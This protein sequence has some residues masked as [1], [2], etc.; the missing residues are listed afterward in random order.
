M[1]EYEIRTGKKWIPETEITF[2]KLL[3][4][5]IIK[6]SGE[7]PKRVYRCV[8]CESNDIEGKFCFRLKTFGI[9]KQK[10]NNQNVC[11]R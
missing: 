8:C 9:M 3:R 6:Y 5:G 11:F 10:S 4:H 1:Q 2:S 7:Q